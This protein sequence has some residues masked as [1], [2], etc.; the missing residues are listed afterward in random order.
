MRDNY[1]A[2]CECFHE[3]AAQFDDFPLINLNVLGE[4][5]YTIGF[6]GESKAKLVA[7]KVI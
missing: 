4:A 1:A 2:Y 7:Q 6:M 5:I 3:L